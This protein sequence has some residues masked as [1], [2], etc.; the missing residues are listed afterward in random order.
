M[1]TRQCT[2]EKAV[3]LM[4]QEFEAVYLLPLQTIKSQFSRMAQEQVASENRPQY[5]TAPESDSDES[6]A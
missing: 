1:A 3:L 2:A 6:K 4:Q 5:D